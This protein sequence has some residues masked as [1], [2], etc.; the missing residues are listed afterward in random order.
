MD[1]RREHMKWYD[2]AELSVSDERKSLNAKIMIYLS[3]A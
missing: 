3:K 1:A 2:D